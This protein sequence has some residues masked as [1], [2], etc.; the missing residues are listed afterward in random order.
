MSRFAVKPNRNPVGLGWG[1][2]M[3]P[4]RACKALPGGF[5]PLSL[6]TLSV[7]LPRIVSQVNC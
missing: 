3:G 5:D 7:I 6:H 4:G 2:R 1:D